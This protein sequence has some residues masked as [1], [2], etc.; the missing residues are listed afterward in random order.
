MSKNC[1][2]PSHKFVIGSA[3]TGADR[4]RP[5]Q[6]GAER[7]RSERSYRVIVTACFPNNLGLHGP[8]FL[9]NNTLVRVGSSIS[10]ARDGPRANVTSSGTN[11]PYD[12][13]VVLWSSYQKKWDSDFL[14]TVS[15]SGPL[16]G[17]KRDSH[18]S[19]FSIAS[20]SR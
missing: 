2:M 10:S 1:K 19:T 20:R 14:L 5:A 18:S 15:A 4:R 3:Q 13:D 8:V 12:R 7:S 6:I 16:N 11:A 9:R 17:C